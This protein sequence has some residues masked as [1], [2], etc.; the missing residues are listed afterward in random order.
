MEQIK[1]EF[2]IDVKVDN[3]DRY[4]GKINKVIKK[5]PYYIKHIR[6][7]TIFLNNQL[8]LTPN[9]KLNEK[10]CNNIQH[11]ILKF[12]NY[13]N[14]TIQDCIAKRKIDKSWYNMLLRQVEEI[15]N[16]MD[17]DDININIF[18]DNILKL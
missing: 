9:E 2:D 18:L 11:I 14:I 15:I 7:I 1:N 13:E 6:T 12:Q 4:I 10:N 16:N 3:K 17:Y 8:S 5:I